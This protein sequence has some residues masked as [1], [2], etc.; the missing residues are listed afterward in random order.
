MSA[1]CFGM[2]ADA[3]PLWEVEEQWESHSRVATASHGL[4]SS[5]HQNKT[6]TEHN[7]N[8]KQHTP[9]ECETVARVLR[10]S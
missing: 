2:Q 8:I 9:S 1:G 7:V 5:E 4:P 6:V 10:Q 3:T